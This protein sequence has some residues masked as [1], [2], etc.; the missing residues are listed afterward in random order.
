MMP[1]NIIRSNTVDQQYEFT[2]TMMWNTMLTCFKDGIKLRRKRSHLR[3]VENC[4][5]GDEAVQWLHKYLSYTRVVTEQQ[6][7]KLLGK[8]V[9]MNVLICVWEKRK[10]DRKNLYMFTE[11]RKP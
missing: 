2:T 5:S 11:D 6:S 3:T 7:V 9:E 4:F 8:L 10:G 1:R